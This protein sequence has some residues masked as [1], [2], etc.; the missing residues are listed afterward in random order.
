MFIIKHKNLFILI[1]AILVVISL[2]SIFTY[3]LNLGTDFKGGTIVEV[4]YGGTL[5][6]KTDIANRVKT[7][8]I[9]TS[10]IQTAG[11]NGYLIKMKPISEDQR[12][13]LLSSLSGGIS[14]STVS[15]SSLSGAS[16]VVKRFSTI[17]P[18]VGAELATKGIIALIAVAL[19][20]IIFIA[21]AFRHVS[22]PVSSWKY[23]LMAVVALC[24]DV[25]IPTGIFA[26][27]GHTRG[28]EIDALFL[29]AL[30]TILALSVSDTIVVF[31]RIRENIKNK[32]SDSFAETVGISI[33]ETINRSLIT[34]LT[35]IFV[36]VVL[37]LFG[38]PTTKDFALVLTLGMFFGT[39][40]SIF[41]ASPLLVM[42]YNRQ[43]AKKLKK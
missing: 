22:R 26:Y 29:T 34:S 19:L 21:I 10:S 39:Y 25:L 36:L 3:G 37:Y 6:D 20:I 43:E 5:P 2:I 40:S 27:L 31:D 4:T 41:L 13:A 17:G 28:T 15:T 30:L 14:S 12:V 7:A 38:S 42:A 33:D 16:F 23:G 11:T 1:S 9:D 18:S 32:I 24:H 35:V 8:G